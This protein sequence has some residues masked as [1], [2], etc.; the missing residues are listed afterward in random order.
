MW[1]EEEFDEACMFRL[2]AC[3][4]RC[5]GNMQTAAGGV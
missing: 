3:G 5:L 2:E 4:W 1:K